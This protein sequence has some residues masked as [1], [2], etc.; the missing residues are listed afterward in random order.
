[1]LEGGSDGMRTIG[2]DGF[3]ATVTPAAPE[4]SL[5]NDVVYWDAA[6]LTD[7]YDELDA[8][9]RDAGI[10]AWTVW[11]PDTD[12]ATAAFLAEHGHRLDGDPEAMVAD[13]ETIERPGQ[14]EG[15]T[16]DGDPQ[17]MTRLNDTV[18]GLAELGG[19][20][21]P[22]LAN[23]RPSDEMHIYMAGKAEPQA[24]VMAY[25]HED[26]C[27]IWFVAT[28]EEAR[29][30]GYAAALMGHALADGRERGRTTSTLQATDMGRPIYERLG[31]RS[32]GEIQLWEKRGTSG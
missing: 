11:V 12:T 6:A 17:V 3:V 4:R 27:S 2:G 25:D 29:G 22:A 18:Y 30:Q 28:L 19:M 9:Y 16:T 32:L 7:A 23:L 5:V 13:L 20:F 1:V 24:C 15:F 31:Y 8:A 21:A 26:D 14:P 10:G